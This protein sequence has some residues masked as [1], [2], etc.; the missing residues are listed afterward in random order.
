[1]K[2]KS[3]NLLGFALISLSFN[4][5][6]ATYRE[7]AGRV[8]IEAE[9]FDSR[10]TNSADHAFLVVPTEDPGNPGGFINARGGLYLQVLPDSGAGP[11]TGLG[12]AGIEPSANFK[13]HIDNPGY[14]QLYLRWGGWDG[15]S[16]SVYARVLGISDDVGG[17]LPDWYRYARTLNSANDFNGGWHGLA[18][19][20][21]TDAGGGDVP[22]VWYLA[23]AGD[24]TIQLSQ[25]EDGAAIDALIFQFSNLAAPD[26]PGPP[27]SDIVGTD[28]KPPV[29]VEALTA[30]NPNGLLVIF[31]EGVSPTTATNKNNYAIDNGVAVNSVGPGLNNYSVVLNTTAITPGRVYNLT[32]N[33]V[34]DTT[35]NTIAANTKVQFYQV[36][37]F[38]ERRVFDVAGGTL[39]A[40]TNSAKF[41]NNLPDA[42][43]YPTLFEGP[44]DYRDNYGTQFRGYITA[45]T[46]G[47][48]VF[49]VCS[50][51]NSALFLSTD[52]NPANKKLIAIETVWST[53]RQWVSS[54]GASDLTAK[55]SDQYAGS[56]WTPPNVITLVG[57]KRY[58]IEANH[59][60]GS[61]GDNI[62]VTWILPGGSDPV[63]GD[64]PIPGKYL[65][66]FGFTPGPVSI[67]TQPANQTATELLPVT[68]TVT[69]GG[70]PPYN[71][72]WFAMEL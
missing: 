2:T 45:P 40:I 15:S 17:I 69:P 32:V 39:P 57:G 41:I 70:S 3:L 68:F 62:A 5:K 36:D 50:D 35:G 10:T 49:F 26:D 55:R 30:G 22:A 11:T 9:H 12:G 48:Y 4:L 21:R 20:E 65:S 56:T 29:L 8:V 64:S 13:V 14:Y 72:Q 7:A 52:E 66:G 27:E 38:I 43:T 16:D 23:A 42:V 61:G 28:T 44:V 18:G 63:D 1:M 67:T 53:T 24:Y 19:F 54:A 60:E 37:G 51:D 46:N 25:R 71:F 59:A 6:A 34:Q 58:Y 33:G 31:N 47:N